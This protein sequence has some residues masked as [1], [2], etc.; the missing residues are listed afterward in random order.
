MDAISLP[1]ST[2]TERIYE[3]P[4]IATSTSR[5]QACTVMPW[6]STAPLTT[7]TNQLPT[8]LAS[9][10]QRRQHRIEPA[11]HRERRH[12]SASTGFTKQT[13]HLNDK[14]WTRENE[15]TQGHYTPQPQLQNVCRTT[16]RR[17]AVVHA[18][19]RP[20]STL[21]STILP[22]THHNSS[23]A[24]NPN[25]SQ[26]L[27]LHSN[28]KLQHAPRSTAL[29]VTMSTTRADQ[30]SRATLP[31]LPTNTLLPHPLALDSRSDSQSPC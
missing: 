12:E 18:A 29:S 10:N 13:R 25:H 8:D 15:A 28:Y 21:T 7:S 31:S 5:R 6:L 26:H 1:D 3:S 17:G 22:S 19:P 16:R 11:L 27:E 2:R 20:R 30:R 24:D 9:P 4:A 23:N 14:D